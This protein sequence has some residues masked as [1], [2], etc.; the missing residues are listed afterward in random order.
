M[1]KQVQTSGQSQEGSQ[2][3]S[4]A[5]KIDPCGSEKS[6]RRQTDQCHLFQLIEYHGHVLEVEDLNFHYNSAVLLPDY[7]PGK[8]NPK[9]PR[10]G[11]INGLAVIRACYLHAKENPSQ[12]IIIAGHTDT[13]GK[14]GYNQKLSMERAENVLHALTG[15]RDGCVKIALKKGKV[16]DY[17]QIL[18]WIALIWG[19][20]C[21]PGEVDNKL[22][23]M[24]RNAIKAFQVAYN[25]KFNASIAQ[26]SKV[27]SQS[28]GAFFDVFMQELMYI[29]EIDEQTLQSFRDQ[30]K[31]VD[32]SCR[33]VG[34]GENFPI[35]QPRQDNYRCQTNRRVEILFFDP[36]EK[37]KLSCHGGGSSCEPNKCQ[38]YDL[39][40]YRYKHIAVKPVP[41]L[42]WIDLQ[43]VDEFGCYVPDVELC[44]VPEG[45]EDY[46]IKTDGKGYWSG[47][48]NTAGNIRVTMADGTPVRYGASD[49][50]KTLTD[51]ET[52]VI[53]P[54]VATRTV[55]DIVV[56]TLSQELIDQRRQQVKRYGRTPGMGRTSV[57]G[58]GQ[59]D[60]EGEKAGKSSKRGGEVEKV[61]RRTV[62]RAVA[63]NLFIA[64]GWSY[65]KAKDTTYPNIEN[66][67][68]LVY[69]WL[70]DHHPTA[71]SRGHFI[72]LVAAGQKIVV[73][74]EKEGKKGEYED[75]GSFNFE[76]T[77]CLKGRYGAHA[78]FEFFGV[79]GNALFVDMNSTSTGLIRAEIKKKKETS[80]SDKTESKNTPDDI[81]EKKPERTETH[82]KIWESIEQK[83][84][85]KFKN[86]V[87]E[88]VD[89]R[90]I[91]IVYTLPPTD[92]SFYYARCG[93]TGLLEEYPN[94]N[95]RR[96][97]HNRNLK[98]AENIKIAYEGYIEGYVRKVRKIG[99]DAKKAKLQGLPHPEFQLYQL[100]PP[101]SNFE[102]PVP[103]GSTP[104][105]YRKIIYAAAT[106]SGFKAWL[107]IARKLDEIWGVRSAG[108][109]WMVFEFTAEAGKFAG[110]FSGCNVKLNFEVDDEFKVTQKTEKTIAL[111]VGGDNASFTTEIDPA[112]GQAKTKVNFGIGKYGIEADS[113]GNVKFSAGAAFAEA[114]NITREFGYGLEISL[115][116]LVAKG[117]T[118]KGEQPPEWV[119]DLPDLKF[120]VGLY[121]QGARDS[122]IMKV[123][124][125]SPGFFQMRPRSQ[126][127]TLDWVSLDWDERYWLE[128]LDWDREKWDSRT[129]PQSCKDKWI[130][131]TAE[132]KMASI[133]LPLPAYD[134][135]WQPFWANYFK[136]AM[137]RLK[138]AN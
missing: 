119:K 108:S 131:L 52:V 19:W 79:T 16:E 37:P 56:P 70:S 115:R 30:L 67:L 27:G 24:T 99:P 93:G 18:K 11:R 102:F 36:S 94:R 96:R 69:G 51:D 15:N 39:K 10:E 42:V 26:D 76:K 104:D 83:N 55:T 7:E 120:K 136:N 125:R 49:A 113:T 41:R 98:V 66:L 21:D 3:S 28:W 43:T 13:T 132:Q 31:F 33:V 100:G 35:E 106:T 121:F 45:G 128:K 54:R 65:D 85:E 101:D 130:M 74:K 97:I 123:L 2:S 138:P 117:F 88:L 72:Q 82:Y 60:R 78:P 9:A 12:A 48:V 22:G 40:I 62:G 4:S 87:K 77:L 5:T 34:C 64:A 91:E 89:Q 38:I 112:T 29:M 103:V 20:N 95:I 47:R 111:T 90:N 129:L 116:D 124:T 109:V 122:D 73:F 63:D 25:K 53:D 8:P 135:S 59:Q 75:K 133:Q 105:E 86:L 68:S 58:G 14:A 114:N 137:R 71:T 23:S 92:H 81:D 6:W 50:T 44:F 1:G 80:D 17:Q 126:F 134:N 32:D 110:P 57:R 84:Q 107:A 46:N 61:T 127:V 118:K